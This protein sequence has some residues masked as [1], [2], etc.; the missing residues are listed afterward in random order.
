MQQLNFKND[1]DRRRF[2]NERNEI[3]GWYVWK[4]DHDLNRRWVRVDLEAFSI[5]VEER[6]FT[7]WRGEEQTSIFWYLHDGAWGDHPFEDYSSNFSAILTGLRT[8]KHKKWPMHLAMHRPKKNHLQAKVTTSAWNP[9]GVR[10]DDERGSDHA[11]ANS[12]RSN[13]HDGATA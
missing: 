6:E 4:Q 13:A 1:D 11:G 9:Q 5:I 2:L 12:G 10:N 8:M 3:E 7:D